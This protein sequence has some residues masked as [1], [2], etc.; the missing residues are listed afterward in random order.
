MRLKSQLSR[1]KTTSD[2]VTLLESD[3]CY[4]Q[5][6]K[7]LGSYMRT[8]TVNTNPGILFI[9]INCLYLFSSVL[10]S[11]HTTSAWILKW[12]RYKT[13]FHIQYV[14]SAHTVYTHQILSKLLSL[15][16]SGC[17]RCKCSPCGNGAPMHIQAKQRHIYIAT[18]T[19]T[20]QNSYEKL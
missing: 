8:Q 14:Y 4:C 19:C 18:C 13:I 12:A 20:I 17:E 3:R 15:L 1:C 10:T 2:I 5:M 16:P 9:H 6:C 7:G 11:L